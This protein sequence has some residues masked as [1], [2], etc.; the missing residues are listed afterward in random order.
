V[1]SSSGVALLCALLTLACWG[2]WSTTLV[3]TSQHGMAFEL[4]YFDWAISFLL[5]GIIVGFIIGSLPGSCGAVDLNG[6]RD[7]GACGKN[8]GSELFNHAFGKYILSLLGGIMWNIAN[9]LLCKGIGLMGQAVGFPLCVGLGLIS[10]SI[11]NYF[12]APDTVKVG[13]LALG[14]AIALLGIIMVGL[15][16]HI[17][18]KEESVKA[19]L[20]DPETLQPE[21]HV[22]LVRKSIICFVGG[23][24]LGISN[25]GV[26][27]ATSGSDALSPPANQTFFSIG[28][29]LSSAILIPLS[30]W[31]PFEG[32]AATTTWKDIWAG[33]KYVNCA[34]HMLATLG[35]FL[36]CLGFFFYNEGNGADQ[37]HPLSPAACYSIGQSAPVVGIL[38]G[39]LF[40][41]EFK[42]SS[43][44]VCGLIPVIVA[45]FVGA[46]VVLANSIPPP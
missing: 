7:D 1:P 5:T 16:A 41:R 43:M 4:F 18:E 23:L 2:S 19:L 37:A 8:Y 33:Y 12:I 14:D 21:Q 35:G 25:L 30:V 28:V 39:T 10:G 13:M 3:L 26:V 9:I 40:F 31:A 24:F 45:L 20:K 32:F 29:F 22:S 6:N 27:N 38:W 36:L 17:K 42:D 11:T 46:I 15:Q 44:K 34:D